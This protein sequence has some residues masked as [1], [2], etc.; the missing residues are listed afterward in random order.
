[1]DAR[2]FHVSGRQMRTF[3]GRARFAMDCMEPEPSR[4]AAGGSVFSALGL[5]IAWARS[6]PA[7]RKFVPV[8]K[9]TV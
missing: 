7:T 5:E 9:G 1:M 3:H 6:L 4:V 8:P 2:W